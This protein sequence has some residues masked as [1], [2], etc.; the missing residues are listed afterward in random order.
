MMHQETGDFKESEYGNVDFGTP[1]DDEEVTMPSHDRNKEVPDFPD[2][3]IRDEQT[4]SNTQRED[5]LLPTEP[6]HG[7]R[8][9]QT[10]RERPPVIDNRPPMD[11]TG[12]AAVR[13]L[14][15]EEV[16]T[17]PRK[18]RPAPETQGAPR[19]VRAVPKPFPDDISSR[20]GGL[21]QKDIGSPVDML[22]DTVSR[23]KK[24]LAIHREKNRLLITP[25]SSQVVQAPRRAALTTTKVQRFDGTTSWEQY[26]QV[27]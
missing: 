23:I 17:P 7:A 4:L 6:L 1:T 8:L 12:G 2:I 26:H 14:M 16:I 27:F 25:A 19:G 20:D 9:R 10:G 22:V 18:G 13:I 24:D 5:W 15:E 21:R 3:D 11:A